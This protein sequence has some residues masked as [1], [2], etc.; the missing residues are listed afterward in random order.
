MKIEE[1]AAVYF[2]PSVAKKNSIINY[3]NYI[4]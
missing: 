3:E 1:R 2:L 4:F